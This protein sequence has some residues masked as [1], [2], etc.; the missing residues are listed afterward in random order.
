MTLCGVQQNSPHSF[1]LYCLGVL[2]WFPG[3][4]HHNGLHNLFL[5]SQETER[6]RQ[7]RVGYA[8]ERKGRRERP[9]QAR[10]PWSEVCG[11]VDEEGG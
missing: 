10:Q 6:E 2:L 3:T 9:S 11:W 8:T 7:R 5:S 4:V 1:N